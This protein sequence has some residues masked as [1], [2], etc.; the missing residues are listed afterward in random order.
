M[1]IKHHK[2][3]EGG[4]FYAEVNGKRQ[5]EMTYTLKANDTVD[6]YHTHVDEALQGEGVGY[7]LVAAAVQFLRQN[8]LK[9]EA[10]CSYAAH[11]F[12]KNREDYADVLV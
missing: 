4:T 1:E 7:K 9:A 6:I 12:K 10:S 3:S 8:N 5:A 2:E 11:V